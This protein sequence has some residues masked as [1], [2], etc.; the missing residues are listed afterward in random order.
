MKRILLSAASATILT[1]CGGEII[2]EQPPGH[3]GDDGGYFLDDGAVA[4]VPGAG[5]KNYDVSRFAL[6]SGLGAI[7]QFVCSTATDC[8][9]PAANQL[10]PGD[11]FLAICAGGDQHFCHFNNHINQSGWDPSAYCLG[12]GVWS[13]KLKCRPGPDG[14]AYC[15][16]YYN[17]FVL[18]DGFTTAKCIDDCSNSDNVNP[19]VCMPTPPDSCWVF[20]AATFGDCD[21]LDF[22]VTRGAETKCEHPCLPSP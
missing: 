1:F 15:S 8:I 16:A 5:C 13:E 19:G 7:S 9:G 21:Q 18:G 17:Q 22:C 4:F 6:H 10:P 20:D 11:A 14:D 12:H 3:A 2:L